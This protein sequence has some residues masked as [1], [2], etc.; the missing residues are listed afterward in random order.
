MVEFYHIDKKRYEKIRTSLLKIS[1]NYPH[2]AKSIDAL[3]RLLGS[4]ENQILTL[5]AFKHMETTENRLRDDNREMATYFHKIFE[6]LTHILLDIHTLGPRFPQTGVYHYMMLKRVKAIFSNVHYSMHEETLFEQHI[7]EE[8][9][10]AFKETERVFKVLRIIT[11]EKIEVYLYRSFRALKRVR[12]LMNELIIGGEEGITY[13][14]NL[15]FNLD[16][17]RAMLRPLEHIRQHMIRSVVFR[18]ESTLNTLKRDIAEC[19]QDDFIK[20]R[21]RS[22]AIFGEKQIE[23]FR[24]EELFP[25][26][27]SREM[28][29]IV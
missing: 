24:E 3:L 12:H 22:R 10:A 1:V 17:L 29:I 27:A 5:N 13:M 9:R 6:D 15:K 20:K 23:E 8:I 14:E 26:V 16:Q 2:H 11:P 7:K 18:I 21:L 19:L 25:N 28:A 4:I